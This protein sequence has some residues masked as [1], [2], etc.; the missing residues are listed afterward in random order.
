MTAANGLKRLGLALVAVIVAGFALLAAA[1]DYLV[2]TT[3]NG[4]TQH[5]VLHVERTATAP[6]SDNGGFGANDD[7]HR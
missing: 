5:Q 1:G 3:V 4:Q 6:T 7:D 2:S